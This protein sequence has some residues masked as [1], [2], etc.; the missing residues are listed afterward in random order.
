M[1][2][3]PCLDHAPASSRNLTYPTLCLHWQATTRGVPSMSK[4][5]STM[6]GSLAR[7]GLLRTGIGACVYCSSDDLLVSLDNWGIDLIESRTMLEF[8]PFAAGSKKTWMVFL[9]AT[10]LRH[11]TARLSSGRVLEVGFICPRKG[12]AVRARGVVLG[13]PEG[14]GAHGG[15]GDELSKKTALC[16]FVFSAP[17]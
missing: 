1:C 17:Q 15:H 13:I 12:A 10:A 5:T 4:L 7:A 16:A 8:E 2:L 11:S 14:L 6:V 9:T 3:G